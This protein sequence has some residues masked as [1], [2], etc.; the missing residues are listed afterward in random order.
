MQTSSASWDRINLSAW[1]II[2]LYIKTFLVTLNSGQFPFLFCQIR[3]LF[4]YWT[5]CLELNFMEHSRHESIFIL[6]YNTIWICVLIFLCCYFP[7]SVYRVY[8]FISAVFRACMKLYHLQLDL[9]WLLFSPFVLLWSPC[10]LTIAK[11]S[12]ATLNNIKE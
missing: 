12:P 8:M 1:T 11:I 3:Y 4:K 2:V 10:L 9:F 6:L 5:F 7:E